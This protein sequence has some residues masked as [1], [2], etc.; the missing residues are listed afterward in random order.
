MPTKEKSALLLGS[1]Y[2]AI[3]I[4]RSLKSRGIKVIVC[5]NDKYDPCH[6][7]SD[8]SIFVDYSIIEEVVNIYQELSPDYLIPSCNDIS[9]N[10]AS[11][12]SDSF[13]LL[14]GFDVRNTTSTLHSKELLREFL[15]ANDLPSPQTYTVSDALSRISPQHPLIVKPVDS[16]SGKGIKVVHN[17]SSL[18][19]SI[20]YAKS[21]SSC[22]NYLIEDF[23]DGR[24]V[25]HSAFIYQGVIQTDFFVDEYCTTYEFQVNCSCHPSS[26]TDEQKQSIRNTIVSLVQKLQLADGLLHTQLIVDSHQ[27]Y[28]IECMR[29]APGD[30]YGHLIGLSTGLNYW[31]MYIS[32]FLGLPVPPP[33]PS[34]TRYIARHTITSCSP[35]THLSYEVTASTDQIEI[36]QLS[37][38]GEFIKAAPYDKI[39]IVFYHY[40]SFDKLIADTPALASRIKIQSLC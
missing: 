11:I 23:I 14:P 21:H 12:I 34:C 35:L 16:T 19:Q 39:S 7:H 37:K 31:D 29:R 8:I 33:T 28:V 40:D 24:L 32:S 1:S 2:S 20:N 10:T 3:P 9:Y 27:A 5:G 30:L 36:F 25:S 17:R 13:G 4:L 38:S 15:H 6:Q 26:L 18:L 22:G